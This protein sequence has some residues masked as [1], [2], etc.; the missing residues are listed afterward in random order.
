MFSCNPALG[1]P[2]STAPHGVLCPRLSLGFS[3]SS[4]GWEEGALAPHGAQIQL[5]PQQPGVVSKPSAPSIQTMVLM[6]WLS[7]TAA[8]LLVVARS[9]GKCVVAI[10]ITESQN[11]SSWKEPSN[12]I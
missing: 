12:S 2:S 8:L 11:P 7:T 6:S 3:G 9:G 10:R 4:E 5:L 1:P